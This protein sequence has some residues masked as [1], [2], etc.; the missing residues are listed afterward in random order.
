MD[1]SAPRRILRPN[2]TPMIDVVFLLLV[3]FIL[4]AR[5]GT[6][7]GIPVATADGSD[8][9]AGPPRLVDVYP[10]AV[11]LNGVEVA[12]AAL[13]EMLGGLVKLPADVIVVRPRGEVSTQR[14]VDI[15]GAL[16]VAGFSNIAFVG[17]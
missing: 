4:A 11:R 5:F 15:M 8:A 17:E 2:L 6:D 12:E 9:Y 1:F 10:G 3:F 16:S 13:A 7:N 14:L